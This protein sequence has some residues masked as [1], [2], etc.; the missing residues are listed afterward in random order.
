MRGEIGLAVENTSHSHDRIFSRILLSK[1]SQI[2]RRDFERWSRRTITLAILAMACSTVIHKHFLAGC[3]RR[4][5]CWSV[6]NLRLL[7]LPCGKYHTSNDKS[8]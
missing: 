7:F 3:G 6:L 2:C 1:S 8:E 4:S 5:T